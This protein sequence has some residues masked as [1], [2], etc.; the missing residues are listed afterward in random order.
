MS[1]PFET[2]EGHSLEGGAHYIVHAKREALNQG[3]S[4]GINKVGKK[5]YFFC[6]YA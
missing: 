5:I 6:N 2:K 4:F 3:R 1:P